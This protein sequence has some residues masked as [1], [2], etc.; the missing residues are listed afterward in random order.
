MPVIAAAVIGGAAAIGGGMLSNKAASDEADYN[1]QW[2]ER[3]SNTQHQRQV[4]DLRAAGLNPILSANQGATSG[5]GAT[6]AQHNVGANVGEAVHQGLSAKRLKQEVEVMK[7][8]V[9]KLE[10]ERENI[11][12]ATDESQTREQSIAFDNVARMYDA[13][14][15]H[16][17]FGNLGAGSAKGAK[18]AESAARGLS[19]A[20]MLYRMS[21]KGK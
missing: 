10:A 9:A 14:F 5:S 13:Q 3:M 16:D 15:M 12:Q 1:R 18:A 7:G 21:G 20:Y 4:A 6:A 2:Q 11:K 8:T 17:I 19:R